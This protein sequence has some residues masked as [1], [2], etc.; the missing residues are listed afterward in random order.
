MVVLAIPCYCEI[1]CPFSLDDIWRVVHSKKANKLPCTTMSGLTY[2]DLTLTTLSCYSS[3]RQHIGSVIRLSIAVFKML[4]P[5]SYI[6]AID[7]VQFCLRLSGIFT[8]FSLA[9]AH[10]VSH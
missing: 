2:L 3:P 9:S 1:P 6:Q 7:S 5:S 4:V 10:V 8:S